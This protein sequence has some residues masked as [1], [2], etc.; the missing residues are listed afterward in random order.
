MFTKSCLKTLKNYTQQKRLYVFWK[1]LFNIAFCEIFNQIIPKDITVYEVS[2]TTLQ[3]F[4]YKFY[5]SYKFHVIK[6][7]GT[8]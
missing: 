5:N 3:V 7:G 8:N 6:L 1:F 4:I 2:E